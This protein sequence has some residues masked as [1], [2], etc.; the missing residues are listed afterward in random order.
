M[1]IL[2]ET[3]RPISS[4]GIQAFFVLGNHQQVLGK[5]K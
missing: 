1:F 2:G 3:S 5:I 4:A